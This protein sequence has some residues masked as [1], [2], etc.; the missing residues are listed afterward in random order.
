MFVCFRKTYVSVCFDWE[1][2]YAVVWFGVYLCCLE[3]SMC[4][5]CF[6]C[7]LLCAVVWCEL[8]V[9]RVCV[10]FMC[11]RVLR[12]VLCALVGFAFAV[13]FFCVGVLIKCLLDVFM[14]CCVLASGFYLRWFV[15]MRVGFDVFVRVVCDLL[16]DV[17]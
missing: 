12:D 11:L 10:R 1:L 3:G 6:V 2:L 14:M 9:V 5:V 7:E 8:V 15:V 17:V 16:R 13:V 4:V